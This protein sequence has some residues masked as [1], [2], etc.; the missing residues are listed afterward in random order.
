MC[1]ES[2]GFAIV[3][4]ERM[5]KYSSS[6]QTCVEVL[7]ADG[8]VVGGVCATCCFSAYTSPAHRVVSHRGAVLL[9][10][11]EKHAIYTYQ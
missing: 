11:S 1:T 10:C 8:S 5:T 4:T 9:Y 3:T 7:R 2:G 6:E